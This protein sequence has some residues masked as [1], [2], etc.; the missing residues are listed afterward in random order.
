MCIPP[1]HLQYKFLEEQLTTKQRRLRVQVVD[2]KQTLGILTHLE[3]KMGSEGGIVTDFRL[4][5]AVYAK[6]RIAK[7]DKVSLWLGANVMLEY[8]TP[9]AVKLLQEN[10]ST[11]KDNLAQ[12]D[13]DTDFLRDQITTTEVN[14][15]RFYNHDVTTRRAAGLP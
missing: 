11:A 2:I 5:D 1:I 14:M 7:T 13:A 10:M 3:S 6:A 15:A 4:A 12:L 9:E 8:D